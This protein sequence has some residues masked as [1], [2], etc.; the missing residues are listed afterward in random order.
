[1]RKR[2]FCLLAGL[3]F[4]YSAL[5]NAAPSKVVLPFDLRV[6]RTYEA[7]LIN[8]H[9][10]NCKSQARGPHNRYSIRIE[11]KLSYALVYIKKETESYTKAALTS[12]A[13][14]AKT[15]A[16]DFAMF[17]L[18]PDGHFELASTDENVQ[19]FRL[20]KDE[21][22]KILASS[23]PRSIGMDISLQ[24]AKQD[25]EKNLQRNILRRY[26][27]LFDIAQLKN[28]RS[29]PEGD[30]DPSIYSYYTW[31]FFVYEAKYS[32]A[33]NGKQEITTQLRPT[34]VTPGGRCD[35]EVLN[36]HDKTTL[37]FSAENEMCKTITTTTTIYEISESNQTL[38]SINR[39]EAKVS[40]GNNSFPS[41]TYL[42]IK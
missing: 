13:D 11:P 30:L 42:E 5:S 10:G 35:Q 22:E 37:F 6:N 32:V 36:K 28:I 18:Y 27:F 31:P 38:K 23:F 8:S 25:F 7:Y 19:A 12:Y 21:V 1:M 17:Q 2:Q 24:V 41:C 16:L 40:T 20:E 15:N 4:S 9:S 3:L 39:I 33:D 26:G 29:S 14:V 34:G